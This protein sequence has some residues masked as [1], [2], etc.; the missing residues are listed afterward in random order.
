MERICNY[1]ADSGVIMFYNPGQRNIAENIDAVLFGVR[2]CF[3]VFL[4]KDEAIEIAM[5]LSQG[6]DRERYRDEIFLLRAIRTLG[7]SIVSITDGSRGAWVY[8]GTFVFHAFSGK[9]ENVVDSTGAGDAYASA[10]LAAFLRDKDLSECIAWG[11]A[12]GRSAIQYYGARDGLLHSNVIEKS[13][14]MVTVKTLLS[15]S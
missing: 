9:V 1:C 10:F 4:N 13:A 15:G 6:E 7:P 12:N 14:S 8:D 11:I 5:H 3:G 2:S